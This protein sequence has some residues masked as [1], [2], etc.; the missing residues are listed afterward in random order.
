MAWPSD[1]AA[2]GVITSAYI[3]SLLDAIKAPQGN[4]T[5]AAGF[6][7][8]QDS[9]TALSYS[10]SWTNYS[11]VTCGSR[12]D[13]QGCVRLRGF[14]AGGTTTA[15]TVAFTLPVGQRPTTTKILPVAYWN[16]AST[17]AA[18]VL[19]VNSN[20]TCMLFGCGA[21]TYVTLDGITFDLS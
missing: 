15:G 18:C 16:G 6:G 2:H 1:P 14:M 17:W 12:L 4:V 9:W 21:N 11:G 8:V 13:K 19:S 20:G 3:K 10:N 5:F 7:L